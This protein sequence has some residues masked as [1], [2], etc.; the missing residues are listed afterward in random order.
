MTT[1]FHARPYGRFIEI[2]SN[3]RKRK[4]YR[5]SQGQIFLGDSFRNGHDVS[6]Q[7][8]FRR[9][10]QSQNLV[11]PACFFLKNRPID[12]HINSTSY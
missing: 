7:I 8:Q 6:A 1:V 11:I 9:E 2:G 3:F 12:F 5:M 10:N 4:L